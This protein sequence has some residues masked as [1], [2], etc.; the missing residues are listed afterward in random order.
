[1]RKE[2][3]EKEENR[4]KCPSIVLGHGSRNHLVHGVRHRTM[5]HLGLRNPHDH[6]VLL[7][8]SRIHLFVAKRCQTDDVN[9]EKGKLASASW[10]ATAR[11]STC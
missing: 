9:W 11:E 3:N 5:I 7:H 8:G 4:Q 10:C 2:V 1:M 6:L